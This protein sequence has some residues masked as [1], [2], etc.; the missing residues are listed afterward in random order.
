MIY[1]SKTKL[2]DAVNEFY[3]QLIEKYKTL[4]FHKTIYKQQQYLEEY[5]KK[6]VTELKQYQSEQLTAN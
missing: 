6:T 5:A 1:N 4:S 3:N 2:L